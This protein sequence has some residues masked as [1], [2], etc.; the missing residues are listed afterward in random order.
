MTMA[1]AGSSKSWLYQ[2]SPRSW[3]RGLLVG[4][5]VVIS[6]FLIA[7]SDVFGSVS[8]FGFTGL[9]LMSMATLYYLVC[10][11]ILTGSLFSFG[12]VGSFGSGGIP[13]MWMLWV[14]WCAVVTA[15]NGVSREGIQNAVLL[16]ILILGM[17]WSA[18]RADPRLSR[19]L[20][21]GIAVAG[22]ILAILFSVQLVQSGFNARGIIGRR[23][24]GI[25][26][27]IVIAV[28]AGHWRIVPFW[29]RLVG[30]VL[31]LEILASGARTAFVIATL[32]VLVS[33]SS[34]RR[35]FVGIVFAVLATAVSVVALIA[36]VEPVRKRFVG[37]DAGITISGIDYNTAGRAEIWG[38]LVSW[39]ERFPLGSGLGR[40][41]RVTVEAVPHIPQP[42]NDYLRL[43]VD[44]G[45]PGVVLWSLGALVIFFVLTRAA[46]LMSGPDA[47]F[48][49][50]GVYCW[51]AFLALMLTDNNLVYSFSVIPTAL[52]VGWSLGL[53]A[54]RL[55][56]VEFT[57]QSATRSLAVRPSPQRLRNNVIRPVSAGDPP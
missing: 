36:Y 23:S 12:T 37:G 56:T 42:H 47:D 41:Q 25:S 55:G 43:L 5:F 45:L 14:G 44:T 28:I 19:V 16:G 3:S 15:A 9:A 33:F 18:Q 4:P 21:L 53:A 40:A 26:A 17:S 52:V 7:T 46:T 49:N 30:I 10:S 50:S 29:V 22:L 54:S 38:A 1:R 39:A 51:F 34:R 11:Q 32:I 6:L 8:I 20:V 2:D 57:F 35:G 27:V 48:L 24:F 13:L 31:F